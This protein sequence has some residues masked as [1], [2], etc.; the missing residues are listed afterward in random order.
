M[1]TIVLHCLL[2]KSLNTFP[3]AKKSE[4]SRLP[5]DSDGIRGILEP[6]TKVFKIDQHF[7]AAVLGLLILFERRS[8]Y[9]NLEFKVSRSPLSQIQ[10]V[11]PFN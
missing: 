11:F 9:L 10:P 2:K 3:F 8:W 4:T 5:I 1:L 7:L 6:L